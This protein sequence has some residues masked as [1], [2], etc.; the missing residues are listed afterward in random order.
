MADKIL[1]EATITRYKL[2]KIPQLTYEESIE[3]LQ[4]LNYLWLRADD[5]GKKELAGYIDRINRRVEEMKH[6]RQE[7][8]V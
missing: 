4:L 7:P 5:D 1:N 6:D 2:D 8:A 3:A